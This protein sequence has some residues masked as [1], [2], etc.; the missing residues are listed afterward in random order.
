MLE[1]HLGC[2]NCENVELG[3]KEWQV[4]CARLAE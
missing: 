4:L 1:T 2:Q 3:E